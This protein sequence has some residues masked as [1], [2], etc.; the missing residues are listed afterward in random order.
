MTIYSFALDSCIVVYSGAK[1]VEE[2]RLHELWFIQTISRC[3]FTAEEKI[4]QKQ[5]GRLRCT[6]TNILL[7]LATKAID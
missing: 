5:E 2:F 7:V 4:E 3:L 6:P 1:F